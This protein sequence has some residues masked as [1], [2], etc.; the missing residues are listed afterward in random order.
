RTN[1]DWLSRDENEVDKYIENPYCGTVFTTKFFYDFLKGLG[2]IENRRKFKLIPKDLPIYIFSGDK[3]PVGNFGKG[4]I[5]L[6]NRYNNL[7][8]KDLKYKLYKDGRH[9]MLNE[10]NRNEVIN[11][12]IQWLNNR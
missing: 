9:E 7:G 8:I 1:F 5:S 4:I 3:D 6:Y 12:L 10:I 2:E 11:D